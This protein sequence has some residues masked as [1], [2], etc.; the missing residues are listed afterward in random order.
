MAR[1]DCMIAALTATENDKPVETPR[2]REERRARHDARLDAS[3]TARLE[4]VIARRASGAFGLLYD[5]MSAHPYGMPQGTTPREPAYRG[6]N[7]DTYRYRVEADGTRTLIGIVS[8][9]AR[10]ASTDDLDVDAPSLTRDDAETMRLIGR[11]PL[12]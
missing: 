8:E 1:I 5:L 7:G 3:M 6:R 11:A 10:V 4:H 9:S 12:D 2:E